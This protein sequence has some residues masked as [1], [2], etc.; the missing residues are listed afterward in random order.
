MKIWTLFRG[1]GIGWFRFFGRGLHWKDTTRYNLLF[2]ERQGYRKSI[3]IG[4][5]RIGYL[6]YKNI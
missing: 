6:K 5:W 1:E 3:T 2:S 4:K